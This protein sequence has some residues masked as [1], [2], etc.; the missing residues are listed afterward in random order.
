M[1]GSTWDL[2]HGWAPNPDSIT[3]ATLCLQAVALL[4]WLS[5]ERLYQDLIDTDCTLRQQF[6]FKHGFYT[7]YI[8][9]PVLI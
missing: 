3:H 2:S 1:T 5:P 4:T 8:N 6:H 7:V 9:K